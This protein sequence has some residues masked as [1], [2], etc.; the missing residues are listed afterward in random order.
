MDGAHDFHDFSAKLLQQSL[1]PQVVDYIRWRAACDT[2]QTENQP[3]PTPPDAAPISINLDLTTACNYQCDHCIDWDILN[4]GVK[5][6]EDE[7]RTSLAEMT[8]RG[9][10][11]VILIGGGEPTV[12][13]RFVDIVRYLKQELKQQVAV[14]T[15]GSR[16]DRLLEA[17][18][19]FEPGDWVRLS[20]DSGTDAT[21]QA[22]HK[23]KQPVTLDEICQWIPQIKE[24]NPRFQV[25]YSFIV[26]WKGA[27]RDDV[28]IVENIHELEIAAKRAKQYRFDYVS[29]KPFLMRQEDNGA[30]IME[31]GR[32]EDELTSVTERIR[33]A[34][35]EARKLEDGTFKIVE[36]TNLR[37][38]E[39]QSWQKYTKQPR[40]CH[41]QA[42]RQVLTPHGVFN[43]PAY[44]S[45]PMAMIADRRGYR[46]EEQVKQTQQKLGDMIVR[47]DAA[48]EC[49]NVT[50][51]YNAT[52][53]WIQDLVDH[54]EKLAALTPQ[55]DRN[56]YFL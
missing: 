53:W 30:E 2:A 46:D 10:R 41:M 19:Y 36:S 21:F 43:C 42:M 52:N 24:R 51:L 40:N 23:P 38:L 9:M 55:A 20:L 39:E 37:L 22:M 31:P 3:S 13:P 49:S 54:P 17:S 14:V 11:S 33:Q 29:V 7:L 8:K 45:V 5:H 6:K 27:M 4:T 28:K 1:W 26:T 44:R 56:D 50:C 32:A 12:Y 35:A 34:V 15:N 48:H 18:E 16:G 47:F 25:G